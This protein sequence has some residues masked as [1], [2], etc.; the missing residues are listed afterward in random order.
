MIENIIVAVSNLPAIYPI[1]ISFKNNDVYTMNCILFVSFASFFSHLIENHK[2]GMPGI[3][4]SPYISYVLN[5]FDVLGCGI[6][7]VRLLYLYYCKFGLDIKVLLD[8][9]YILL[10]A[11]LMLRISEYD[12]YNPNL[13]ILYITTHCLWHILI[14]GFMGKFIKILYYK[15][16]QFV[17]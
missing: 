3:G 12:K 10:L 15:N 11:F 16:E 6:T 2:H 14:F 9:K 17:L 4:Y 7:M 13:K 8:N 5:R 1:Y